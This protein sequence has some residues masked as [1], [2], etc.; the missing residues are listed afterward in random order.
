M[1]TDAVLETIQLL[2]DHDVAVWIGGGWGVDALI[3]RQTRDHR[4]LDVSIAAGDKATALAALEGTG[5]A[6]VTDWRPT[7]VAL[8]HPASGEIDV[9]PI[10]FEEDGSAWLPGID[11]QRFEY[12]PGSFT[13]DTIL[14][15]RVA[16]INA[17]LQLTFHLGY[18]PTEMDRADM[19]SLAE[20]DLITLP[21][22]YR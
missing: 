1:R 3:G 15:A 14:G 9:H 2:T 10:T 8:V 6:I 4:D 22:E 21:A 19:R 11:G 16:C 12:P 13:T 20:A 5:F 18:E 7:R 17:A